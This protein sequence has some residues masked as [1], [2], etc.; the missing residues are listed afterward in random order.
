MGEILDNG[1]PVGRPRS[2]NSAGQ[3]PFRQVLDRAIDR[4]R[5]TGAAGP[6]LGL[7]EVGQDH[8]A[9]GVTS[10]GHEVRFLP[11]EC[12]ELILQALEALGV[13]AGKAD[14]LGGEVPGRVIPGVFVDHHDAPDVHCLDS[15][16]FLRRETPLDP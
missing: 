8:A 10:P 11:E 7:G 14:E 9:P 2:F 4:Q 13:D 12:L 16:H 1:D 6:G 3:G 15:S 5:Q